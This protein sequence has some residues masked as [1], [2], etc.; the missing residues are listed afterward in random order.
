M[1]QLDMVMKGSFLIF[2]LIYK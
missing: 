2:E 1:S